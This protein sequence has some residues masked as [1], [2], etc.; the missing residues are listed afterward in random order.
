MSEMQT[1][2]SKAMES[3][4]RKV[5]QAKANLA[6]VKREEKQKL[7]KE[8]DH[9]KFIMGGLIVKYFPECYDFSEQEM[10]R[11]I[12]CAFKNRDVLNMISVVEKDRKQEPPETAYF[13]SEESQHVAPAA[14]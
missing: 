6:R 11:I 13:D 14:P 1:E 3:A 12:A 5:E 8:Q 7:R 10:N 2:N 4:L 9:H